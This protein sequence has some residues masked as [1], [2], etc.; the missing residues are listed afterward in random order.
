MKVAVILGSQETMMKKRIPLVLFIP[1]FILSF[2]NGSLDS[3]Y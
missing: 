1:V 2:Q 3:L